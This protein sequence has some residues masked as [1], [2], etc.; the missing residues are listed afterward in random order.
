MT[1]ET[2]GLDGA[3]TGV[4]TE[5]APTVSSER[6]QQALLRHW[7]LA[8]PRLRPLDSERDLNV[9]VDREFV[10]KITNPA[11]DPGVVD[12]E[13]R[14]LEHV[15]ACDPSLAV[16]ALVPTQAGKP[17]AHL[18]DDSGRECLARLITVVPGAPLEGT[19]LDPD[20]AA[21]VGEVSGRVSAALQGFFH[22]VAGRTLMW[23]IRR[24]PEAV[25]AAEGDVAVRLGGLADR[26]R[27]ALEATR[28]LPSWVQH[29]DVTLTNVLAGDDG[30]MGLIDFGDMHHTAA[31]CELAATLTSVLRGTG[32]SP[33][34]L[35]PL[36]EAV[37]RGYQRRRVLSTAEAEILGELVIARLLSTLAVSATRRERHRTNHRYITQYDTG[38][39]QLLTALSALEP[40]DL[41]DRM[42]RLAGARDL[43]GAIAPQ[44]LPE[45]RAA[46][47]GGPLSPLFYRR[48]L[49]LVRGEGPWLLSADGSRYLDAYNNV[50]VVGHAH[51]TV[52]NAV[53]TQLAAL[54]THSR[55]LHAGIVDLAE[56]ILATMPP[57]LDTCLFTTSG[58]EANELAWR[59][60]VAATGGDGAIVAEHAY[61][62]ASAWM[63]DLSSNEWPEGYRPRRVATYRAPHG[64]AAGLTAEVAAGRIEGAAA[65]LEAEGG[66]AA[67]VA[68]DSQFTSEGILDAPASFL[69]GL[70]EGARTAGALSLADEVQSG[71][72]RSGPRLWRFALAGITPDIVTLGKPMGAGY[73]IGAVVTRRDIARTLARDYEYFS[74][75]AATPVAAAAGHAVLDVLEATGLPA[76]AVEVGALLRERMREVAAAQ[77]LLGEVRGT[78]LLAGVDVLSDGTRTSRAVAGELLDALVAEGILAGRTGPRGDVLKVRPP[79][80]WEARHVEVFVEGLSGALRRL[81]G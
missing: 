64:P 28:A 17:V 59:L 37:L 50:A 2:A 52:T 76:R 25:R 54:N 66:R 56:R 47:M 42:V 80:V 30:R 41:A 67:L 20:L 26:V 16:P 79:L 81:G 46:A 34:R 38:S 65:A 55:Y 45:R 68:A 39:E 29:G 7:A 21:R 27:P 61:H 23:D 69:A 48:P 18:R 12:M 33:E 15:R 77:P 72:G 35:W 78:G 51:P 62:G 60:A 58:T 22:P 73:P 43:A 31:V 8:G 57:P 13:V 70:V 75:F 49:E 44:A 74:T 4:F 36:T 10:L 53:G 40:A 71:Y 63:A 19:R 32:G 11:E 14:A 24:A 5:P 3:A 1:T 9:L 6:L